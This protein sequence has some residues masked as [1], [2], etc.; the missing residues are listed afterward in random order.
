MSTASGRR[1]AG[2]FRSLPVNLTHYTT[3]RGFMGIIDSGEIWLSN[4]SFLNDRRELL[5]GL[6]AAAKVIKDFTSDRAYG[7]WHKPLNRILARLKAG[8]IPNTYAACFCEKS[9]ILSQWRGYG[10]NEQG[11]AIVLDRR[12]LSRVLEATKATLF[13]IVYG[14]LKSADQITQ[15]L[16][17]NL[18]DIEKA[19]NKGDYSNDE[20]EQEAY[21]VICRLLPQ[22]KHIGFSDECEWRIVI[23]HSTLRS[24]VNFRANANV[25]VPY[26]KQSLDEGGLLPIE[27][28]RVGPGREQELTKRSVEL[29]LESKGYLDTE[30]KISSVP[31]R[32]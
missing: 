32:L 6:D 27:Y 29:Y 30:V 26:L 9:D 24:S 2:K 1:L 13:P 25:M 3:L 14:Q 4:V 5:Y 19:A 15:D 28:I 11:I 17:E 23:Q 20:K 12:K 16:S 21:S 31:Y 8:K 18:D 22:F 7:E 10:G